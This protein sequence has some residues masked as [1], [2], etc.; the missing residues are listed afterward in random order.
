MTTRAYNVELSLTDAERAYVR[1]MINRHT[2]IIPWSGCWLWERSVAGKG[3]GVMRVRG[4][5]VYA[6]R[7]SALVLAGLQT[8]GMVVMHRCDVPACCNPDHLSVGTC[9]E[10]HN[11]MWSKGRATPTTKRGGFDDETVR[12]IFARRVAGELAV[13]IARSLGVRRSRIERLLSGRCGSIRQLRRL[14]LKPLYSDGRSALR[15]WTDADEARA[16]HLRS[17]G[18]TW[19]QVG[20][21]LGCTYQIAHELANRSNRK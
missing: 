21:E 2:M 7:M 4:T 16:R 10:N 11:D 19:R 15:K 20:D 6:H 9:Q 13:S 18:L 17:L 5:Q 1:E 3:Y 12:S 8:A 14:G